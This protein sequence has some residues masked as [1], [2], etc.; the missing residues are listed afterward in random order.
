V[1]VL[2]EGVGTKHCDSVYFADVRGS[3]PDLVQAVGRALR[4]GGC[5]AGAARPVGVVP[6][7]PPRDRP[8]RNR[9]N[10]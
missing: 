9:P 8:A 6:Q 2:G 10:G 3:M 4:E 5:A 7:A 1:K